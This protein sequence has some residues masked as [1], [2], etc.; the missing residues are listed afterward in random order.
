MRILFAGSENPVVALL[1]L[2]ATNQKLVD[3]SCDFKRWAAL[4][5]DI[6]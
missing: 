1:C 2:D 6:V 3:S 4:M 5:E